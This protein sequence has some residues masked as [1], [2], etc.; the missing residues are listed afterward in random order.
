MRI[1]YTILLISGC[2]WIFA[3]PSPVSAQEKP[4]KP[5]DVQ[6]STLQNLNF[7]IF[8]FGDGTGSTV[9][10]SPDGARTGTGSVI[11]MSSSN[12]SP[13]LYEVEALPGTIITLLNG[14]DTELT[15]GNG[16]KMILHVGTSLPENPFIATM[17]RTSVFIG[18]TLIVGDAMTSPAGSYS[19][20]FSITFIQQ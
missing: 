7:G 12:Y 1:L 10:I 15:S 17:G 4:P 19:G 8:C 3:G 20:S 13:A 14:P 18:G 2:L 6:V 5:I 16:G 11:L 9:T